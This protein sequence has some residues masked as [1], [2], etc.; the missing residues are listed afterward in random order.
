MYIT[1]VCQDEL[2]NNAFLFYATQ[3]HSLYSFNYATKTVRPGI[4]WPRFLKR[5]FGL[6]ISHNLIDGWCSV[7][8][9]S[10]VFRESNQV[11]SLFV[12]TL[13]CSVLSLNFAFDVELPTAKLLQLCKFLRRI[14]PAVNLLGGSGSI[15]SRV[16]PKTLKLV[17][18]GALAKRSAIKCSAEDE[19][20]RE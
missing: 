18:V 12:S 4:V 8:S 16:K 5:R 10:V 19:I 1:R 20:N 2:A 11:Y 17:S 7:V 6:I 15:L 9:S 3:E 13:R 14:L